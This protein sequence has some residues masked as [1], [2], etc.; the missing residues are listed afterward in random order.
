MDED[1]SGEIDFHEFTSWWVKQGDGVKNRV[2]LK[3]FEETMA[4]LGSE[5]ISTVVIDTAAGPEQVRLVSPRGLFRLVI[6]S[7]SGHCREFHEWVQTIKTTTRNERGQR[8][9]CVF[10]VPDV[11][12]LTKDF[13]LRNIL[14]TT[15][16]KDGWLFHKTEAVGVKASVLGVTGCELKVFTMPQLLPHKPN[17]L[18]V[19]GY[20]TIAGMTPTEVDK[21]LR[22]PLSR[23]QWD[24]LSADMQ[25]LK[26][27]H[28]G[29]AMV[30]QSFYDFRFPFHPS[31]IPTT[32]LVLAHT[33]RLDTD[34]TI[35]HAA[36]TGAYDGVIKP[37]GKTSAVAGEVYC[38]GLI[39][40]PAR[41]GTATKLTVMV[42]I[43]PGA[44]T[45]IPVVAQRLFKDFFV[46]DQIEKIYNFLLD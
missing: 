4:S 11:A 12:A 10:N 8:R 22:D 39:I 21:R 2:M 26:T 23:A 18:C 42:C 34:G 31:P 43:Q 14:V 3:A 46:S 16:N 29:D 20:T 7:K 30:T 38:S 45:Q 40:A 37:R 24:L 6:R 36:G 35:I 17:L 41:K 28:D 19:K 25:V 44:G 33:R 32:E 27:M 9:K 15:K 13:V 1:G 5:D